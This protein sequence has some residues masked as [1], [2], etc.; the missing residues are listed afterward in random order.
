MITTNFVNTYLVNAD[1]NAKKL[2]YFDKIIRNFDLNIVCDKNDFPSDSGICKWPKIPNNLFV[3][4]SPSTDRYYFYLYDKSIE[5]GQF[6][7]GDIDDYL[8]EY[9]DGRYLLLNEVWVDRDPEEIRESVLIDLQNNKCIQISHNDYRDSESW[10]SFGNRFYTIDNGRYVL[11][12]YSFMEIVNGD[13]EYDA[14]INSLDTGVT[15]IPTDW[16]DESYASCVFYHIYDSV[17]GTLDDIYSGNPLEMG[18]EATNLIDY[19]QDDFDN[20]TIRQIDGCNCLFN[21]KTNKFIGGIEKSR[22]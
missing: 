4:K 21:K 18:I 11:C 1:N 12:S 20:M 6:I 15:P 13:D 2:P 9:C 19:T 14:Y 5:P 17:T 16:D 7:F 22:K 8:F 10:E 3:L